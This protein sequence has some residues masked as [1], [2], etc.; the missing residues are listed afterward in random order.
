MADAVTTYA[1]TAG[2]FAFLTAVLF[3]SR[4]KRYSQGYGETN[5]EEN[6]TGREA[7]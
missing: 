3:A 6:S 5:I 2:I 1:I 7:T 4:A